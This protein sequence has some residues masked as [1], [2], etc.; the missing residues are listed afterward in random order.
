MALSILAGCSSSQEGNAEDMHLNAPVVKSKG[1]T[2]DQKARGLSE[3][4]TRGM[5]EKNIGEKR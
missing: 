2:D 5:G 3:E 4:T 1:N